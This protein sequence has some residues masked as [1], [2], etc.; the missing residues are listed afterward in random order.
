MLAEVESGARPAAPP[1][2]SSTTAKSSTVKSENG[3][4]DALDTPKKP[5]KPRST[6]TTPRAKKTD[7][8]IGGRVTK[9]KDSSPIKKTGAVSVGSIKQELESSGSSMYEDA[10]MEVNADGVAEE[11]GFDSSFDFGMIGEL[12]V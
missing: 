1:R 11:L 7:K 4:T 8:V 6:T 12:E 3:D 5:R 10:G 2:G 9:N